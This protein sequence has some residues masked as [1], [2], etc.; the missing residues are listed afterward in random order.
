VLTQAHFKSRKPGKSAEQAARQREQLLANVP[1][2]QRDK[3]DESM[4]SSAADLGMV[5]NIALLSNSRDNG[6]IGVNMYCDDEASFVDAALNPRASEIAYC[7]GKQM[8][9]TSILVL[10]WATMTF[11]SPARVMTSCDMHEQ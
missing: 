3:I 2:E 10:S 1:P 8:Q 7:C 5:E 9:V 11:K 4:L 6:F